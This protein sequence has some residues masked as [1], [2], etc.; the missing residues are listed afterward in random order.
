MTAPG[1]VSPPRQ[2]W[3]HGRYSSD[4]RRLAAPP[5]RQSRAKE[6]TRYRGR[7]RLGCWP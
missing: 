3:H 4:S 2:H 6:R 7:K 1:Q 5:S